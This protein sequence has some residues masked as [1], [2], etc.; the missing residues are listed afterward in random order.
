MDPLLLWMPQQPLSKK[1]IVLD[2]FFNYCWGWVRRNGFLLIT[3]S[4]LHFSSNQPWLSRASSVCHTRTSSIDNYGDHNAIDDVV[5]ITNSSLQ[6]YVQHLCISDQSLNATSTNIT[7]DWPRACVGAVS[8]QRSSHHLRYVS[9][10]HLRSI[11]K[12]DTKYRQ[13]RFIQ[14]NLHRNVANIDKSSKTYHI[15]R[16]IL[17]NHRRH[18]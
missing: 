11:T 12:Y 5:P 17:S 16:I 1:N 15:Q 6:T 10:L 18:R 7:D 3:D 4:P 14:L 13:I 8:N 2:C 9:C